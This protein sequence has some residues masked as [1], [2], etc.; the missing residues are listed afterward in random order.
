MSLAIF[1]Y[2]IAENSPSPASLWC[3]DKAATPFRVWVYTSTMN[4]ERLLPFFVWHYKFAQ[5]FVVYDYN[6]TDR[7]RE[8][9]GMCSKIIL[10]DVPE[11]STAEEHMAFT[12]Y[13][14]NQAWKEARG[15]ADYIIM[16]DLDEF[17]VFNASGGIP[18]LLAM[19][20]GRS[21]IFKT[22]AYDMV[23]LDTN[24]TLERPLTEQV[25][26]GYRANPVFY[27]KVL[28]FSTTLEDISYSPGAHFVHPRGANISVYSSLLLLNLHQKMAFG[29]D[30]AKENV[31]KLREFFKMNKFPGGWGGQYA[32]YELWRSSV[33]GK[34]EKII[35]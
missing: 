11:L 9:A 19:D 25:K 1:N 2:A 8:I 16:A 33:S 13:F 4:G 23:N 12:S 29:E 3:E 28:M 26:W 7:T 5:Q 10:R 6:S 27:D 20:E 34:L 24:V 22:I 30:Y 14:R 17:L 35:P 32:S 15:K 31:K 21:A 18:A